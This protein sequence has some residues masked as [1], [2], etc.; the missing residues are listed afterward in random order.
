MFQKSTKKEPSFERLKSTL[1]QMALSSNWYALIV[2][3]QETILVQTVPP[4]VPEWLNYG[5]FRNV[6]TKLVFSEKVQRGDQGKFFK[7]RPKGSP[8]LKGPKQLWR[9]RHYPLIS[10]HL[11]RKD[12]TRF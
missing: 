4:K 9:K 10:M 11:K 6:T 7:K 3:R 8:R 5:N 2:Q 12:W 1:A